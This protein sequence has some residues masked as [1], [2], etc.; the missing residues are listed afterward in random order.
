MYINV[1]MCAFVC[2]NVCMHVCINLCMN[3]APL[4]AFMT[5]GWLHQCMY[6]CM[7]VVCMYGCMS[8]CMHACI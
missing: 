5:V 8:V 4:Y 7:D 1:C 3:S 6:D 2:I